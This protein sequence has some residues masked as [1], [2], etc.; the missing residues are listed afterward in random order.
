MQTRYRIDD[1]QETY[2]QVSDF[3][4]LF[5]ATSQDFAPLYKALEAAPSFAPG[6]TIFGDRIIQAGDH[7]YTQKS[8]LPSTH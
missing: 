7:S 5:H 4:D 8:H 3:N 6:E 1:F 2:F